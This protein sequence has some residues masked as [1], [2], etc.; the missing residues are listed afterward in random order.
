MISNVEDAWIFRL[1]LFFKYLNVVLINIV[2]TFRV[3]DYL[4]DFPTLYFYPL[5]FVLFIYSYFLLPFWFTFH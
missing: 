1:H 4:K 3:S 2:L 5:P